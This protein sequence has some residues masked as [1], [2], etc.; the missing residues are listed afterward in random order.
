MGLAP[1]R[2]LWPQLTNWAPAAESRSPDITAFNRDLGGLITSFRLPSAARRLGPWPINL[3]TTF[4]CAS[5]GGDITFRTIGICLR[6]RALEW[7]D[8]IALSV[9]H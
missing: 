3:N 5:F 7:R 9:E 6:R 2:Y 4:G 1:V 8:A